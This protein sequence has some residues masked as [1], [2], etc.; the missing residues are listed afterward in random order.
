MIPSASLT[1]F[2]SYGKFAKSVFGCSSRFDTAIFAN[3]SP[4]AFRVPHVGLMAGAAALGVVTWTGLR[5]SLR[6]LLGV[7]TVT[8]VVLG[9]V[10]GR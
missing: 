9:I 8:A 6:T 5:F 7:M 3:S 4:P 10:V 2:S 1:E